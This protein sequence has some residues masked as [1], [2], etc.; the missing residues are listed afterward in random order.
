MTK[1]PKTDPEIRMWYNSLFWLTFRSLLAH[2]GK[3]RNSQNW[4][5]C[6]KVNQKWLKI[7]QKV[8]KWE[9]DHVFIF[10]SLLLTFSLL[11]HFL[12]SWQSE[13]EGTKKEKMSQKWELNSCFIC[14]SLLVHF[15][16]FRSL[17][18]KMRKWAKGEPKVRKWTNSDST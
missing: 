17:C 16:T 13:Q 11:V 9:L 1:R 4:A 8:R 10:E 6:E 2:F 18:Q 14:E 12:I 3:M 7:I 15:L 5:K